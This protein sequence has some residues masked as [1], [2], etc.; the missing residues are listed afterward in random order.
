VSAD[1]GGRLPELD[2]ALQGQTPQAVVEE[3][4]DWLG[5]PLRLRIASYVGAGPVPDSLVTS[6][7]SL[8]AV[9]DSV[10]VCET[11]RDTHI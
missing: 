6:V 5:V 10:V 3:Q 4:W 1:F 7:R 11:P 9:G 8:V 2:V